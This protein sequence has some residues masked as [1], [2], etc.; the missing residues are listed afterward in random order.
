M[1]EIDDISSEYKKMSKE[2]SDKEVVN[3]CDRCV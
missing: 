1:R 3:I 2:L